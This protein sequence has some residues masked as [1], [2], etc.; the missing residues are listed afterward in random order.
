MIDGDDNEI[1]ESESEDNS[2]KEIDEIQEITTLEHFTSIL[3][4]AHALAA[5]RDREKWRKQSKT[6]V[7]N[8]LR[9]K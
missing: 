4:K 9:T 1:S 5:E 6:Y 8:L 7:G 3:Q 2:D